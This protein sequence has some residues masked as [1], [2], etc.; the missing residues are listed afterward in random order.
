MNLCLVCLNVSRCRIQSKVRSEIGKLINAQIKRFTL[1]CTEND[2][3]EYL[4]ET[5]IPKDIPKFTKNSQEQK[6]RAKSA[7][8]LKQRLEIMQNKMKSK[9]AKPSDR[10]LKKKQQKKLKL[11]MK[12]KLISAAKSM[13]NEK[14]KTGKVQVKTEQNGFNEEDV[15]P[16]I[17]QEKDSKK[18]NEEG[19]LLFPKF[20]FAARPSQAKKSK[21]ESK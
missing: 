5:K 6:P 12:K 21:S 13:K 19:K 2:D 17:K 16:E 1:F 10:T 4:L 11:E 20:E 7:E 14:M 15:K 3:G 18:F 9:K 8:E